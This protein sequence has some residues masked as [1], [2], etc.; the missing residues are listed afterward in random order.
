MVKILNIF[1]VF[2][3]SRCDLIGYN[4]LGNNVHSHASYR[5]DRVLPSY[6]LQLMMQLVQNQEIS[7][8]DIAQISKK[9]HVGKNRR[10][11]RKNRRF[12]Q[13]HRVMGGGRM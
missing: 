5:N 12:R 11:K 6:E 7:P 8:S 3:F 2:T 9:I 1:L 10:N 13:Y 4:R